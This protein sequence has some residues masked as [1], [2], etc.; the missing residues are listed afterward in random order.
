MG[1]RVKEKLARDEVVT[2]VLTVSPSGELV[3]TLAAAGFDYVIVDLMYGSISWRD[4]AEMCRTARMSGI[5]PIIRLQSEP[6]VIQDNRQVVVD[7]GRAF[8]VGAQGV[9]WSVTSAKELE[10][11]VEVSRGWH[12]E[13]QT[14]PWTRDEFDAHVAGLA[15]LTFVAPVIE[16]G[17]GLDAVEDIAQVPGVDAL[18]AATTDTAVFLGHGVNSEHPEVW[19]AV[20]RI[21]AACDEGGIALW[22]NTGM[23]YSTFPEM[24]E[25]AERLLARGTRILLYQT[26]ELLLQMAGKLVLAEMKQ[27]AALK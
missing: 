11:V 9:T 27:P 24:N 21:K 4:A 14:I 13:L 16:S 15:D 18:M 1:N 19:A 10:Q 8:A 7:A 2:G 12:R 5:T 6:W 25:R 3:Q 20:D 23:G 26:A 17:F 22:A